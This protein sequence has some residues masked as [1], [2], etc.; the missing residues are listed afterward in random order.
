MKLLV[1]LGNSR[2]KWAWLEDGALRDPGA[3]PHD[4]ASA[5]VTAALEQDGRRP[6][7]IV[8]AGVASAALTNAIA[9]RLS[10]AF[11][12]PVRTIVTGRAACG[13]RNGY[14]D[15]AQLG[16]DRWLALIAAW[17]RYRQALCVVDAGTAI[18][19]DALAGDG[20]HLGGYI[21]PGPELMRASLLCGTGRLAA[22]VAGPTEPTGDPPAFGRDTEAC[23]RLGARRGIAALVESSLALLAGNGARPLLVVTGGG[24]DALAEGLPVNAR[25]HPLLVLEGLAA[26]CREAG[27]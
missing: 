1:D 7:E 25:V 2:L 10:G 16:V 12:A 21:V 22:A 5:S 17:A 24:A 20:G 14:R 19:I 9:A 18:T 23:I 6:E 3:A 15:P 8:M 27:S 4:Q 11:R 26:S 13:V